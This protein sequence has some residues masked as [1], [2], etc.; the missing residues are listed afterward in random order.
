VQVKAELKKSQTTV[1]QINMA[2]LQTKLL[3]RLNRL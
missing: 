1:Q 3:R 2:T